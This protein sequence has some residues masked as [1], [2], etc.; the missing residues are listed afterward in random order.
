M[1]TR[2]KIINMQ[3]E[4]DKDVLVKQSNSATSQT[5]IKPG[6]SAEFWLYPSNQL[7]VL[8]VDQEKNGEAEASPS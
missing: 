5:K 8:E 6:G 7:Q 2:I 1:T 3:E 4:Y